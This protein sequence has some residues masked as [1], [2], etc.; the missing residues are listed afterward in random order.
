[1][2]LD[3]LACEA[4]LLTR[5]QS[6]K[7]IAG[8]KAAVN[9]KIVRDPAARVDPQ[10]DTVTVEGKACRARAPL[11]LMLHKPAGV[12]C[13]TK[14]PKEATVLSLLPDQWRRPG[15]APAGRLDKDTTGFVLLT[16]DGAFAHKVISPRKSVWKTYLA[17]LDGPVT[18][19]VAQA[20]RRGVALNDGPCLPAEIRAVEGAEQTAEVRI[21]E[22]RYHQIKRMFAACGLHVISLKRTAVGGVQLDPA[23]ASGQA[24]PLT[25]EEKNRIV[26]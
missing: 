4:L 22:G 17:E 14:D 23:L 18:E 21:R 11:Y 26:L 8:G 10:R 15:L 20:F 7:L 1:M 16:D 5:S 6:R 13:A 12:V 2:R 3:R 24:R 19:A 25:E 9:G